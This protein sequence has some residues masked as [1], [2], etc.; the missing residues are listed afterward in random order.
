MA[1][2]VSGLEGVAVAVVAPADEV[3]LAL[4]IVGAGALTQPAG[5]LSGAAPGV[6]HATIAYIVKMD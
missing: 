6:A 1:T 5:L 4:A 2:V 3:P